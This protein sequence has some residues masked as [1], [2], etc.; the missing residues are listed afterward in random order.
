MKLTTNQGEGHGTMDRRRT[1]PLRYVPGD[2]GDS[3]VDQVI[4]DE[5]MLDEEDVIV[6]N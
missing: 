5:W 6:L 1:N 4:V 2:G 3:E